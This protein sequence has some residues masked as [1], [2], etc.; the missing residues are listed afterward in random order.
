[1]PIWGT[2]AE[3][4]VVA[5]LRL[6]A[7]GN[8]HV[9]PDT[10]QGPALALADCLQ[11]PDGDLA[12]GRNDVVMARM[13]ERPGVAVRRVVERPGL[14]APA[15]GFPQF[16]EPPTCPRSV[17]RLWCSLPAGC[18]AVVPGHPRQRLPVWFSPGPA[19]QHCPVAATCC[20]SSCGPPRGRFSGRGCG[21]RCPASH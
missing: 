1:L 5:G 13:V 7:G 2:A 17:A 19:G 9:V 21:A 18:L 4:P 14:S 16:P 15:L 12:D 11:L 20:S 3:Q 8:G 10:A 6:L